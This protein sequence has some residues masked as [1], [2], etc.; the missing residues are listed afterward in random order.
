MSSFTQF[1]I[2]F[3]GPEVDQDQ[4]SALIASAA[5]GLSRDGDIA[6]PFTSIFGDWNETGEYHAFWVTPNEGQL[7]EVNGDRITFRGESRN[8][9]PVRFLLRISEQ[10]PALAFHIE[11]VT[12][13]TMVEAWFVQDGRAKLMEAFVDTIR[14][15]QVWYVKDGVSLG[16]LP[17]WIEQHYPLYE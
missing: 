1:T 10:F 13:H 3:C 11:S 9:P 12:E 4:F 15:P 17:D 14:E 7:F 8:T 2:S 5:W 6:I 16:P